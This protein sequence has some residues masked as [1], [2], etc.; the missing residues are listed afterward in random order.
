LLVRWA[1]TD[2]AEAVAA[3]CVAGIAGAGEGASG[4]GAGVLACVRSGVA[5]VVFWELIIALS[6]SDLLTMTIPTD[7]TYLCICV[8][9]SK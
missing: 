4:V 7:Y 5:L 9:V 1:L 3:E 2:A 6:T 8:H